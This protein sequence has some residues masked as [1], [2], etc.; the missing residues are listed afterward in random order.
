MG[1]VL[2][3]PLVLSSALRISRIGSAACSL[4]N[5]ASGELRGSRGSRTTGAQKTLVT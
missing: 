5:R 3:G 2:A 1:E 4:L